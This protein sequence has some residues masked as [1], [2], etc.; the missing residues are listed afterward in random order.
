MNIEIWNKEETDRLAIISPDGKPDNK[1]K[2]LDY[3]SDK[4]GYSVCNFK[5]VRPAKYYFEDLED[6]NIV[7]LDNWE[8]EIE[9]VS[10]EG[11]EFSIDCVGFSSRLRNMGTD[12]L[13]DSLDPLE[14]GSTY[15]VDHILTDEKL[16]LLSG[17]IDTKDHE[18]LA[19]IDFSPGRK[20]EEIINQINEYNGYRAT[21]LKE[22]KLNYKPREAAPAYFVRMADCEE[23]RKINRTRRQIINWVQVAYSPD[24]DIFDYIIAEDTTSQDNHGKRC[25][26]YSITGDTDDAQQVADTVIAA[27]KDLKASSALTTDI[28][29]DG[30]VLIDPAEVEACKVLCVEDFL[31]TEEMQNLP[32]VNEYNTW[33]LAEVSYSNGKVTLSPGEED[34]RIDI[35][36]KRIGD[37][38]VF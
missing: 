3:K 10:R 35:L 34:D 23:K 33:E 25:A 24:G 38:W 4:W 9:G 21:V 16:G 7:K 2:D 8:G 19:G 12:Y 27:R 11:N 1:Y 18:I 28:I 13:I 37:K 6:S 30:S 15:I 29:S 26:Y 5:L 17:E 20:Y 32:A 14:K 36:L 31:A 22:R